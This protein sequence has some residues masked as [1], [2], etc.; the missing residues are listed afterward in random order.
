MTEPSNDKR[1]GGAIASA[2][3]AFDPNGA[4]GRKLKSFYDAVETEPVPDRLLDLLE[5]LD[6]AE[7]RAESGS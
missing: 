1:H 6:E 3:A 4:I 5:K 2:T 7:R